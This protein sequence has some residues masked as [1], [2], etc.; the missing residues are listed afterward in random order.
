MIMK[1]IKAISMAVKSKGNDRY[2]ELEWHQQLAK[3]Q[4]KKELV[5]RLKAELEAKGHVINIL[6]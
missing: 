4:A 3:R 6:V 1:P 5:A 2:A